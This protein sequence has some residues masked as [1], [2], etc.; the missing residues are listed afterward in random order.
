MA[1]TKNCFLDNVPTPTETQTKMH[2]IA[3]QAPGCHGF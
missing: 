3:A 1:T 2:E